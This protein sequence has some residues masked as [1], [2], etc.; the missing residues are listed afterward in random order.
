M[1]QA[2]YNLTGKPF[3]LSPDPGFFFPSRGHKRALAYLRY[4]LKQDEG[5]VVITGAPGTGKTTL[6]KILLNEMG[7]SNVVVAHLTTTQLDGAEILRMVA[8]SFNLRYENLDKATLLK[9][10]ES[11]LLARARERKRALLV[12]D[13]AQNL[14]ATALEELRMLSNLQAGDKPLVQTFLLGQDQFKRTL[15]HKDMEQLRQRVIANFHLSSL[16]ADESQRYIESRLSQV[17]WSGDP[18]FA[19]LAYEKIHEYTEGT[20]RRINMLCDRVLLFACMEERRQITAETIQQVIKELEQEKEGDPIERLKQ[21][22]RIAQES[23]KKTGQAKKPTAKSTAKRTAV[24]PVEN[25]VTQEI[26][27]PDIDATLLMKTGKQDMLG[28]EETMSLKGPEA[29]KLRQATLAG[30]DRH[31]N[32]ANKAKSKSKSKPKPKSKEKVRPSTTAAKRV[33]DKHDPMETAQIMGNTLAKHQSAKPKLSAPVRA[34]ETPERDLFRVIPGGK[35][36]VPAD[37]GMEKT[38]QTSSSTASKRASQTPTAEDVV[39]RRILRLVLA[40]HRSPSRFPGLDSTIQPLPEGITELLELAVSDDQTLMQVSP[41]AVMGISPVMLRAAVRFFVRRSLFIDDADDHRVLGLQMGADQS[42]IEKHYDLLMRLLRQDKQRGSADTVARIGAAYES[43]SRVDHAVRLSQKSAVPISEAKTEL[44]IS[45]VK[46]QQDKT[47]S[48]AKTKLVNVND[49]LSFD[50]TDV[51]KDPGNDDGDMITRVGE[52]FTFE[53]QD[54]GTSHKRMRYAGHMA[55]LGVAALVIILGLYI[56]QF[57]PSGGKSVQPEQAIN[58]PEQPDLAVAV[59]AEMSATFADLD[60]PAASNDN[61]ET[62]TLSDDQVSTQSDIADLLKKMEARRMKIRKTRH[63]RNQEELDRSQ[64][65]ALDSQQDRTIV[66][67]DQGE[68]STSSGGLLAAITPVAGVASSSQSINSDTVGIISDTSQTSSRKVV[69]IQTRR[70]T[71]SRASL[72]PSPRLTANPKRNANV[73]AVPLALGAAVATSASTTNAQVASVDIS[74]RLS[75]QAQA[76]GQPPIKTSDLENVLTEFSRAYQAGDINKLTD[77]FA[78]DARTNSQTSVVGIRT[79]YLDL[80]Q[81][82]AFRAM[83]FPTIRWENQGPDRVRGLGTYEARIKSKGAVNPKIYTGKLTMRIESRNSELKISQFYFTEDTVK[84]LGDTQTKE[85]TTVSQTEVDR[86]ITAFVESY[87]GGNLGQ[88]M[89]MFS[90]NARTNDQTTLAGIRKD[91]QDLFN[92]TTARQMFLKNMVWSYEANRVSGGGDFEVL[93][94]STNS[95]EF[96]SYKGKITIKLQKDAGYLKL[97]QFFHNTQ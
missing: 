74:P 42:L 17:G 3:R 80:F 91:H 76:G 23:V 18:S 24:A 47:K 29:D 34:N 79:D 39:L 30:K 7:D 77:L 26:P 35:Q 54:E 36:A 89:S 48:D 67:A 72:V 59:N 22:T 83:S 19:E 5:F 52:A 55:V 65:E 93:I 86:F 33:A 37:T 81:A 12:I 25:I 6:A 15:N 57:E 96:V 75:P 92:G 82:T 46:E 71:T 97:T 14:P 85:A 78:L 94:Q 8:A 68:G 20:P 90:P 50:Y 9:S 88:L 16:A 70:S 38:I 43:L 13:E 51:L 62:E 56:V 44:Y 10:L 64:T 69:K 63:A 58:S 32:S 53:D 84:D 73:V 1:Y 40:Y 28:M 60:S 21:S 11:F 4:G 61:Q 66:V 2:F 95:D 87:E 45:D 31:A 49:D 27:K 41:A